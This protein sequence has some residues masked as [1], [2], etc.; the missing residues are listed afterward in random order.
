M[1]L[2]FCFLVSFLSLN[3]LPLEL[4]EN[5]SKTSNPNKINQSFELSQITLILNNQNHDVITELTAPLLSVDSSSEKLSI[6]NPLLKIKEGN[7]SSKT[8]RASRGLY[9]RTSNLLEFEKNVQIKISSITQN[10]LLDTNKLI[11][12]NQAGS[13]I[14]PV[15]TYFQSNDFHIHS[16]SLKIVDFLERQNKIIFENG[17]IIN[18]ET[19]EELG[20]ASKIKFYLESD[21][22]IMQ[23]LAV[24][25]QKA[26]SIQADE[27][28]YN[29]VLKKI[30]K[31]INSKI[32]NNS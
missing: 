19:N 24:I 3:L 7:K 10:L 31:S 29:P 17:I 23:G 22:L 1:K 8:I 16:K 27:I 4:Q 21:L 15:D 12:D 5:S 30:I 28:H 14:S 18:P 26:I 20:S 9:N 32:I 6:L 13:I 11:L 2:F 25:K